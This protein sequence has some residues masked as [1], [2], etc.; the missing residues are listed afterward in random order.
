MNKLNVKII[1]VPFKFGLKE[2]MIA[3]VHFRNKPEIC[4][5][6]RDA[7]KPDEEKLSGIKKQIRDI[8]LW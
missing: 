1:L 5:M 7:K 4:K 6:I 3:L 2:K 8:F